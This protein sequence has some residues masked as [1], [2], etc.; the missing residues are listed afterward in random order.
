MNGSVYQRQKAKGKS[1]AATRRRGDTERDRETA[2]IYSF[3]SPRR[4]VAVSPRPAC[5]ATNGGAVKLKKA[6][7]R[8]A[9]LLIFMTVRIDC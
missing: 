8:M 9:L 7:A 2:T 4:R 5:G 6:S 3:F 1:D